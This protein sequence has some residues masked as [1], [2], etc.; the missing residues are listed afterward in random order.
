MPKNFDVLGRDDNHEQIPTG[1]SILTH[2]STGSPNNSPL[3][4]SDSVIN[5]SIPVNA[6]EFVLKPSTDLRISE[7]PA[8]ST[9][10]VIGAGT[11]QAIGVARMDNIYIIRDSADGTLNF[12]FVTV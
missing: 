10:F 11:V 7:N 4:Y 3:S 2:D 9:Y 6:A 12:Y 1:C 5:I 8:M